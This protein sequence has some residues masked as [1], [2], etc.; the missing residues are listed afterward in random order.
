MKE[1]VSLRVILAKNLKP[2]LSLWTGTFKERW[3][4]F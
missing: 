4:F 1:A 2:R 3:I